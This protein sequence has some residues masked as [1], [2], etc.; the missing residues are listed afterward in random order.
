[1]WTIWRSKEGITE[2]QDVNFAMRHLYLSAELSLLSRHARLQMQRRCIPEAAVELILDFA[3]STPAGNG[4]Q[5]YRFDNRSWAA[6]AGHLGS[7][8]R[9]FEKYRNAY[10]IEANDG[11]VVTAAWL[12]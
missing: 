6:A 2:K 8:A 3:T 7:Q 11:T 5:R 4:T 10:V 9:I 1:M 12:Y